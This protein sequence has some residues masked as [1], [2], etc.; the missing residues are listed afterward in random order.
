MTAHMAHYRG[1]DVDWSVELARDD[2]M[3][4]VPWSSDDGRVRFYDLRRQPDLLLYVDE[5]SRYEELGE[6]LSL[7]NSQHSRVQTAKADV[8]FTRDLGD[9]ET[10]FG[11]V[12]KQASYVDLIF[13]DLAPRLSFEEHETFAKEITKLLKRA[14]EISAAAEFVVRRCHYEPG[15]SNKPEFASG[16]YITFELSGYGDDEDDA[17]R[18]WGIAL[19]L[20]GNAILQLSAAQRPAAEGG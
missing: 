12:C 14:P 1:M 18:R 4:T 6:L 9:A 11:A 16:F 7:L 15:E 10:V 13:A 5:A 2:P 20:I 3:L 8:W 19:R 17:R